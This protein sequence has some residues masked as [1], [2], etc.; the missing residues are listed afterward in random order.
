MIGTTLLLLCCAGGAWLTWQSI[1][2]KDEEK[3]AL[4]KKYQSTEAWLKQK[5]TRVEVI[6]SAKQAWIEKE[7]TIKVKT[8]KEKP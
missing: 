7:M 3:Q 4:L 8:S 1:K 2:I 6:T 5:N